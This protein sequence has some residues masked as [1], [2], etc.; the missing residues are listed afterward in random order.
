MLH[1]L[2]PIWKLPIVGDLLY[3]LFWVT[4]WYFMCPI[5][6]I[7]G[8]CKRLKFGTSVVWVTKQKAEAVFDGVKLLQSRDPEMFSRF[9]VKQRLIIYYIPTRGTDRKANHRA[10]LMYDTFTNLGAEGVACFIVQ[11]LMV[12]AA[13]GRINPHRMDE[14]QNAALKSVSRNMMEWLSEHSF[15]PGLI[16]AYQKV[17]DRQMQRAAV[18]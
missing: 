2:K 5:S 1:P 15:Q 11:S 18:A 4:G 10:F 8:G 14:Q 3:H 9:M 6:A 17:V 12:A 16:S 7:L 13:V